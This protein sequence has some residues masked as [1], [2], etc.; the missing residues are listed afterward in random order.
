MHFSSHNAFLFNPNFIFR[1]K[2]S[3]MKRYSNIA[4]L[5]TF[6]PYWEWTWCHC[7]LCLVGCQGVLKLFLDGVWL[8][9]RNPYSFL[10]I[11][12]AKMA[13]MLFFF[14]LFF[15]IFENR[16]PFLRAFLPQ[17]P[18]IL[19]FFAN[20]VIWNLLLHFFGTKTGPWW[21]GLRIFGEKL[22]HMGSTSPYALTC[23]LFI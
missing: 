2:P 17:K 21:P 16:D 10:R 15:E 20:L 7:V 13:D 14:F 8:E 23:E 11:S 18:L 4:H 22:T 1:A 9:V 3:L 5:Q 19:P 6:I 12:P